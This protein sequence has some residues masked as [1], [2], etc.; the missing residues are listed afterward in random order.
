M[1]FRTIEWRDNKV[2]MIDQ[3]RLP[4]EE[5]Y[6]EYT[7]F[8]SVAEAIRGMIIRGAPAIGVAAAMGIALGAREIIADTHESFFRQLDNVCN[9]MARTRPTAVNLF[10]AIERMKRVAESH[11]DK[12]LNSIREILKA[13]AIRIEEEDLEI[14]RAIGRNGAP[15]IK[16]G[17]TILTHCNAG[18]LATAG[19]GTALG[20][21]RAAHEAGKRIQVFAD[22]T[23]PWLQGA[24]LTSW[25]L[26]KD[27]IPVTLISD[28]MAGYFMR[29]GEID[30]CVVGADRIAANGD[31]ANKI[32]TY[33][34]AVLA[35]ENKI[36][37]YVAAPVSTLDLSL[38]S[39]EDIP[40]EERHSRE[41]T[42]LQG[43]PVAPEGV[44]VRNPAFD[45]TPA[46]YIAG[47]I[48]EKGVV[49]GDYEKELRALVGR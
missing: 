6:N 40:I 8:Q 4:G 36:P 39:G 41:V 24:R 33:S 2:V 32:G 18:G 19:Y 46:R 44:K 16:E 22:E 47:I 30:V 7:D 35:K 12:D 21:I 17:A 13:E 38:K 27:G 10:W 28:N 20:V 26:M 1:S 48:T 25:E 11:R 9:V 3:T 14:C 45:V 5:V 29:K 15:L 34:V 49:R 23:R 31:T 37:F 43:L 42:H